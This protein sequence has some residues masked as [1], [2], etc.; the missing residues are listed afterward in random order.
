MQRSK[1]N[2]FLGGLASKGVEQFLDRERGTSGSLEQGH[3]GP[4]PDGRPE[5]GN[6]KGARGFSVA[7]SWR[8]SWWGF[9]VSY[10]SPD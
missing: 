6:S 9:L 1:L 7:G 4:Y 5:A 2:T 3:T 8:T 10:S